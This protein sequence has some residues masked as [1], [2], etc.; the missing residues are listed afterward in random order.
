MW[1]KLQRDMRHR[2]IGGVCS[3]IASFLGFNVFP[4]RMFIRFLFIAFFPTLWWI[5]LLLWIFLPPQ[6]LYEI[7]E[8]PVQER[9]ATVYR[10]R[11]KVEVKRL[12][13]DDVIVMSQGRVSERVLAKVTAIDAAVRALMPHLTWR[14]TLVQPEYATVKRAALEYFPQTLQRYLSLPRDYAE[15]H[16]LVTGQTP[17]EKLLADFGVLENTLNNVLESLY[18]NDKINVP[19]DLKRLN[20]HFVARETPVDD[21]N[22]TLDELVERIRGKVSEDIFK[23]VTNIRAA[24]VSVL[25]QIAELGA[26]TTQ[27]AYNVK[28]TALEY[29]PDALDKYLSLPD[30]FAE[31]TTL[32]NGKTAKETLLEQLELLEETMKNI[33]GDV[34]EED[35][36]ALLIHGRFL[37]EKF[38]D[39]KFA[40]PLEQDE[41]KIKFPD[42]SRVETEKVK[43]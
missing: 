15:Q 14:R 10:P 5:Y 29:L 22:R 12:D 17:E 3:G 41:Q 32:S 2:W 25:P 19:A 6:K 37:K 13:I 4:V 40:L 16:R 11:V 33:V 26:G 34:Y 7:E 18:S 38:A 23:K 36:Q 9:K 8:L 39:Q 1:R 20:E 43:S 42:L 21:M 35:A 31:T 28:Q 24:I 30:G 27:E